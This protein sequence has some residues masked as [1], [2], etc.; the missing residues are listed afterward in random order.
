[1][2]HFL[3]FLL[4]KCD[5]ELRYPG[6]PSLDVDILRCTARSGPSLSFFALRELLSLALDV[7]RTKL[8]GIELRRYGKA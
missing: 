5:K 7:V 2:G 6:L 3:F 4:R 8:Q 1:M